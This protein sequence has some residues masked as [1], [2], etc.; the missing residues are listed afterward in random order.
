MRNLL[1]FL[2][3]AGLTQQLAAEAVDPQNII[4]ENVYIASENA[5]NAPIN[6][7]IG[8]NKL[9]LLTKD[10][11][12]GPDG[13]VVLDANGGY[14]V[15]NLVLGKSPSFMI[16]DKDPRIDFEVLLNN[17]TH[18]TFVIHNGELRRN[19]LLYA[20]DMFE[21]KDE[22]YRWHA[23]TPPPVALPTHYEGERWNHWTT[24]KTSNTF[25]SVLALDRQYWLSQNDDSTQQVGDLSQ[26]EGGEI[27]DWRFGLLGTLNYFDRPWGYN[28]VVGTNAFDKRFVV[29][30]QERFRFV[31]YRLDIPIAEGVKLSVGKQKEP[32]SMERIMTLINL[33]MLERSS[34]A[35]AF[36]PSRNF[37][38]HLSG[39]ALN[40]RI[41]WAGGVFN[42]FIDSGVSIDKGATAVVGRVSWLPFVSED[43]SNLV[44]LALAAR[45][46]NGNQ[47]YVYRTTPEFN[48]APLF[49]DTGTGIAD[50]TRQ[51]DVEVS[52]RRGSFWLAAEY[53]GT[54][55]DSPTFGPLDFSG[56]NITGSWIL[57]GE[58]RDY[59]PKSGTFGPVPVSRSVYQNGKG[60]WELVS[61]WSSIDLT[62]GPVQGGEMDILSLGLNWWLSSTFSVSLNYRYIT[63]DKDSLHGKSSGVDARV[64]LKLN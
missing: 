6:L 38:V 13:F 5:E 39:N 19:S 58:M 54:H 41:S 37:G 25:F 46:E 14:L 60:A 49:V 3:L 29:E 40:R 62:D 10:D 32:I 12:P 51:Y 28:V 31:D 57:T 61:R 11:I 43:Q 63:N 1:L 7:L 30:N 18:S 26:Y 35:S 45:Y 44:H 42:D 27:R 22:K 34:V 17:K 23:Y 20:K 8:D 24:E 36:L 4:I 64:L 9:E 50:E 53:V 21:P 55:V 33:P 16:L 52:W 59:H 48:N 15:G 47:G 56:Y 2:V